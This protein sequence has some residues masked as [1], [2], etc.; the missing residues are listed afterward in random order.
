MLTAELA[1]TLEPVMKEPPAGTDDLKPLQGDVL[2]ALRLIVRI[3]LLQS[4]GNLL[5]RRTFNRALFVRNRVKS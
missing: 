1:L 3:F 4:L 2:V 5:A